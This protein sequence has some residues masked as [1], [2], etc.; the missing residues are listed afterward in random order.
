M[1]TIMIVANVDC[2]DNNY[3]YNNNISDIDYNHYTCYDN[4]T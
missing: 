4:W 2:G 3:G 1:I